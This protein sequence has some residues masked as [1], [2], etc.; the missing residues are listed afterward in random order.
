MAFEVLQMVMDLVYVSVRKPTVGAYRL[1]I[2]SGG[3]NFRT[4]SFRSIMKCVKAK[5]I[6]A[7]VYELT[8]ADEAF[9]PRSCTTWSCTNGERT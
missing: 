6:P 7:L 9:P 5:R 3:D 2:K 8:M 1:T 4:S